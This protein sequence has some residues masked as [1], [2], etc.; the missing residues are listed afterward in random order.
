MQHVGTLN[1]QP[2]NFSKKLGIIVPYRNR[3]EHLK[4]FIPHM[5][6]YFARDKLDRFLDVEV[7]IVEQSGTGPFN[8]GLLKN[9]GA[10]L[11]KERCDYFCFH[12]VDY[13][14]IWSDYSYP[15][16]PT[17]LI[18]YGLS[19]N[20]DY[21][22]FFGAVVAIDKNHFFSAN[23]YPN[24]YKGWGPEDLELRLRLST[25]GLNIQKRDGTFKA[26]P[27]QSNGF[28]REGVYTEEAEITHKIFESRQQ[29][30]DSFM[31]V[32]GVL[33]AEFEVVGGNQ[34]RVDGTVKSHWVHFMVKID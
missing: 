7:Y 14:P 23:G 34:I 22:K 10:Q 20:E 31:K 21:E 5:S 12:D 29:K 8:R 28:K 16:F 19:L 3:L 1:F 26:L 4:S 6:T 32:D 25:I 18:W 17:R 9:I 2:Q 15:A 24:C 27:H 13:L 33:Q 30:F 11:A